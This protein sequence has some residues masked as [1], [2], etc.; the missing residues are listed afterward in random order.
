MDHHPAWVGH[1]TGGFRS[2]QCTRADYGQ[3]AVG[4]SLTTSTAQT[5]NEPTTPKFFQHGSGTGRERSASALLVMQAE[6]RLKAR[7]RLKHNAKPMRIPP[8]IIAEMCRLPYAHCG[9]GGTCVD[10]VNSYS[11][12]CDPGF[13]ETDIDGD[14]VCENLDECG[15]GAC[16]MNALSSARRNGAV[17]PTT[18]ECYPNVDAMTRKAPRGVSLS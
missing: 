2:T 9:L 4:G 12:D 1:L 8:S 18:V 15:A 14:K 11:C 7:P 13:R 5:P 16:L 3:E 10:D 17:D 6:Q